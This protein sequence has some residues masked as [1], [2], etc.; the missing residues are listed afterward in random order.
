MFDLS[1]RLDLYI[2]QIDI[3]RYV[4]ALLMAGCCITNEYTC[5]D[6]ITF[7]IYRLYDDMRI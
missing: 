3:E 6:F 1:T 7:S 2:I 5:I 4:F